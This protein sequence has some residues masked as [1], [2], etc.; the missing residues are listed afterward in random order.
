LGNRSRPRPEGKGERNTFCSNVGEKEV[1]IS[2]LED[3][4]PAKEKGGTVGLGREAGGNSRQPGFRRKKRGAP[5]A[6]KLQEGGRG[7]SGRRKSVL[8]GKGQGGI[9]GFGEEKKG[10]LPL[11][12]RGRGRETIQ[13]RRKRQPS[14]L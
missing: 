9:A 6:R 8:V 11:V 10:S 4:D 3:R 7:P 12:R 5:I 2:L 1:L 13:G 14:L